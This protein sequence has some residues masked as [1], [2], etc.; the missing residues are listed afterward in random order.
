MPDETPGGP[1][2]V[3][4]ENPDHGR[5]LVRTA[6]DLASL[7]DGT[8]RLV[9]VAAKPHN[10][11][12]GVFSDETIRSR[13]AVESHALLDQ[14][15]V[16]ADVTVERNVVVAR[17]VARGLLD[18]VAETDPSALVVGWQDRSRPRDVVL[19]TTV[20][21]LVARAPCDLYVERVGR[22]ANGVGSV[23]LPVAGGPHVA[24]AARVAGAVATRNDARVHVCSVY[25]SD[26]DPAA[27]QQ[28][29]DAGR[30]ALSSVAPDVPV[31]TRIVDAADITGAIA[32]DAPA[33]DVVVLGATRQGAVR[34]RVAGTVARRVA[35]RTDQTVVLARYRASAGGI[36]GR[37]GGLIRR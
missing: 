24:A 8:V 2:L 14:V 27:A 21:T 35:G 23:L 20:D 33:H 1:V 7:G 16:P 11:P 25:A 28:F 32:A 22:E 10:S 19:G 13:Y 5:Q 34:G 17:S 9:T 26:G 30:E 36:V 15:A 12:F 18:A 29:V 37:V 3:G 6:G 31:E 4:V